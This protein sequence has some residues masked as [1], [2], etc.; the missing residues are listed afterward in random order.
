MSSDIEIKNSVFGNLSITVRASSVEIEI[1]GI[2]KDDGWDD[3][4]EVVGV[5]FNPK[6]KEDR[7]AIKN[8]IW[9]LQHQLEIHN[10]NEE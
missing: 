5:S 3:G 6:D 7:E 8:L 1:E 10:E 4:N 2:P 9:H